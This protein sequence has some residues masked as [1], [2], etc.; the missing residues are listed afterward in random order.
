MCLMGN[1]DLHDYVQLGG[2]VDGLGEEVVVL[3]VLVVGDEGAVHHVHVVVGRGGVVVVGW[4]E[5]L[6]VVRWREGGHLL[7][8][9]VGLGVP[10]SVSHQA[11]CISYCDPFL[12]ARFT[13]LISNF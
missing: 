5:A 2:E 12:A 6:A 9:H 7:G 8:V 11:H 13:W 1:L 4:L 10:Q 3:D